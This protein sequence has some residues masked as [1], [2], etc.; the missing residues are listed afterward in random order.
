[1]ADQGYFGISMDFN[2]VQRV[3][4][5]ANGQFVWASMLLTFLQSPMLSLEERLAI[6]ENIQ[7]PQGMESLYSKMLG[8]LVR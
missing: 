4:Q 3:S 8:M 1:M 6:L 5:I 7:A 2:I